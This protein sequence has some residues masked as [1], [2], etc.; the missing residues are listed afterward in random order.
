MEEEKLW[1]ALGFSVSTIIAVFAQFVIYKYHYNK[2]I[3]MQTLLT[4]VTILGTK[5]WAFVVPVHNL[6]QCL[7]EIVGPFNAAIAK[8]LALIEMYVVQ[9][10]MLSIL[11]ETLTKFCIISWGPWLANVNEEACIKKLKLS[12]ILIPPCLMVVEFS[13]FSTFN[14]LAGFQSKHLHQVTSN[15]RFSITTATLMAMNILTVI[16]LQIRVEYDAIMADDILGGGCLVTL[17]KWIRSNNATNN[18]VDNE[19]LVS[20]LEQDLKTIRFLLI[21]TSILTPIIV[22]QQTGGGAS[23]KW[24][25]LI[26]MILLS[27]VVPLALV[28]RHPSMKSRASKI[29]WKILCLRQS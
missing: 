10:W 2:P 27:D 28:W 24:N 4:S 29:I 23:S 25:L 9:A 16:G 26:S 15:A 8:L 21:I 3:G 12:L 5:V 7:A 18:V 20:K 19:A 14:D 11:Y 17:I 13:L 22:Y 6:E 1:L